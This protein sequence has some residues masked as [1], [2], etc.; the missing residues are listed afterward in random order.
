MNSDLEIARLDTK[1]AGFVLGHAE[2]YAWRLSLAN[3]E[4]PGAVSGSGAGRRRSGRCSGPARL[5]SGEGQARSS[6]GEPTMRFSF[7]VGVLLVLCG[8]AS[9]QCANGVCRPGIVVVIGARQP[10]PVI[11]TKP[12]PAKQPP[13]PPCRCVGTCPGGCG[14]GCGKF[15]RQWYLLPYRA[16]HTHQGR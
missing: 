1:L 14:C 4:A 5:R 15:V 6:F 8:L 7:A 2:R 16:R 10:A 11:V 12:P 9:A 3:K 13:A